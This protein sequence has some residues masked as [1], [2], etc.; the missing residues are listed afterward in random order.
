MPPTFPTRLDRRR[1]LLLAVLQAADT[2]ESTCVTQTQPKSDPA[3][4]K[5]ITLISNQKE[6]E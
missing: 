1:Q 5:T 3:I 6:T 2:K 4:V